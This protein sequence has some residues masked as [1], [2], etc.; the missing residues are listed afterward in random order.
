MG[1]L[2][3]PPR[4]QREIQKT[5]WIQQRAEHRAAI[6]RLI[7]FSDPVSREWQPVLRKLD[8]LLRLGRARPQA[9]EP[10]MNV[11]PGYYHM[12]R[13]NETAPATVIP[14]TGPD[15]ESF[16]EPDSGL[17]RSLEAND[18]QNPH[19]YAAVIERERNKELVVEKARQADLEEVNAE[20][21]E[22]WASASRAQVSMTDTPW[23]QNSQGARGRKA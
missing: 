11:K 16:A 7:D 13:E 10:G 21:M 1:D 3:L 18:L 14:I 20:V 2:L 9:Y 5:K 23:S 17:L 8:P 12:V 6:E 22:R 19:V 4:V 15:G